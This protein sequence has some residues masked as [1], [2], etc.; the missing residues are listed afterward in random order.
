MNMLE[1]NLMSELIDDRSKNESNGDKA[2]NKYA[3]DLIEGGGLS[4][5]SDLLKIK[6]VKE[7][8]KDKWFKRLIKRLFKVYNINDMDEIA[9]WMTAMRLDGDNISI[10]I[11]VKDHDDLNDINRRLYQSSNIDDKSDE[12]P[13]LES[14]EIIAVVGGVKFK[15]YVDADN[16]GQKPN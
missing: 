13:Q 9:A 1:N 2:R 8:K 11:K 10:N 7:E 15:F 12:V 3:R 14:N 4:M 16:Q 6:S 5:I